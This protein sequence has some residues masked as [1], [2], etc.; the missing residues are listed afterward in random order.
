MKLVSEFRLTYSMILN[1]LRVERL[2]VEDMMMRSFSEVDRHRKEKTLKTRLDELL[3]KKQNLTSLRSG[4]ASGHTAELDAFYHIATDYLKIKEKNWN[5]LLN[6]QGVAK[7][8]IPGRVILVNFK[9]ETNIPCALLNVDQSSHEKTFSVITLKNP[10]ELKE[11]QTTFEDYLS[12]ANPAW[13]ES[14]GFASSD[15][16]VLNIKSSAI[17]MYCTDNSPEVLCSMK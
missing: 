12:L 5:L 11:D 8:L 13:E 16:C 15:H 4:V 6:Q 3:K 10:V 17:G 9:N 7:S 14:F 2:R 1:L